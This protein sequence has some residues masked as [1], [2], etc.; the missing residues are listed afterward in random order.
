M[1]LAS[2]VFHNILSNFQKNPNCDQNLVTVGHTW[3]LFCVPDRV[4]SQHCPN[5]AQKPQFSCFFDDGGELW[6]LFVI[7][8][9]GFAAGKNMGVREHQSNNPTTIYCA[10]ESKWHP[11]FLNL[12]STGRT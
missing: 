9:L 11:I 5:Q 3:S 4:L 6:T 2:F 12:F 7:D 8:L 10:V 1:Y